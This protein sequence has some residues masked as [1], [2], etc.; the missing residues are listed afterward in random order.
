MPDCED[1]TLEA[2][3]AFISASL[4]GQSRHYVMSEEVP[5]DWDSQPVKVLVGKNFN[6]VVKTP[7][8]SVFVLFCESLLLLQAPAPLS[9]Y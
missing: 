1:M 7:Q 4:D 9:K 8:R 2:M 5:Q 3:T 6:E